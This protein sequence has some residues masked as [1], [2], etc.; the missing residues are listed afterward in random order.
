MG[1]CVWLVAQQQSFSYQGSTISLT[2]WLL[3]AEASTRLHNR[4]QEPCISGCLL[5][6]KAQQ[7]TGKPRPYLECGQAVQS[8]SAAPLQLL[9]TDINVHHARLLGTHAQCSSRRQGLSILPGLDGLRGGFAGSLHT[10]L[11][12]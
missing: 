9:G 12:N 11:S 7:T 1:D 10:P 6:P 5:S 3:F 4:G 2:V 8:Q